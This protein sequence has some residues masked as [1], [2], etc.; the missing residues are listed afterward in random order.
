MEILWKLFVMNISVKD[1]VVK[2]I[3]SRSA[4]AFIRKWH[5][6][7]KVTV[8]SQLH[9][10]CFV[11]KVLH[12]V[13][14]FGASLDKRK[15]QGLVKDT[16]WSGFLELNRMAFDEVLPKNSES[17]CLS[18]CLRLIKKYSPHIKWVVSFADATQCGDGTQYRA[19]GF[20]LTGIKENHN[21]AKLSNGSVIHKMTLESNPTS[22]RKE[23][24]GKSYYEITDG[25]Y[26]FKKYVNYLG[27]EILTGY[28]LRYL[29][30]LDTSYRS[31]LTVAEIPYS[32]IDEL[33]IGMYKGVRKDYASLV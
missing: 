6:S 21:L 30:F 15:M 5:Y 24:D 4:N 14:S 22:A 16:S 2:R 27:G 29:F 9:F 28:Q 10:G 1:I 25:R 31:K 8:N 12:G 20:I 7:G 33:K 19:C 17:R 18:V 26:N 32:K 11:G 13:L 23:L 3:D